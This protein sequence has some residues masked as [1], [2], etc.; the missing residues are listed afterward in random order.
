MT[1]SCV[2]EKGEFSFRSPRKPKDRIFRVRDF[3][4]RRTAEVDSEGKRI[5]KDEGTGND[6][7]GG[8]D[9]LGKYT[10]ED[11]AVTVYVDS[12]RRAE[13]EYS[14]GSWKLEKSDKCG[15]GS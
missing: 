15:A 4:G 8:L 10:F 2:P 13:L 1:R 6:G 11:S 14:D 9:L 3:E 7:C 12:C 5:V